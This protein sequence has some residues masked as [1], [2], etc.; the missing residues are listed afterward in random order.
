MIFAVPPSTPSCSQTGQISVG[1]SA[2]LKCSSFEGAPKPV[3]NWVR[4]GSSPTPSPGSMVQGKGQ[5]HQQ[6]G[7][8]DLGKS[9]I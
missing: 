6:R 7:A 1:G 8:Q 2:A 3:Y 9:G 4:L 5:E